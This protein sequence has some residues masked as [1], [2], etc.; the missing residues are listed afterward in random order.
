VVSREDV[1][2]R[3]RSQVPVVGTVRSTAGGDT[4]YA[5]VVNALTGPAAAP[6]IDGTDSRVLLSAGA[7]AAQATVTTYTADGEQVETTKVE[8]PAEATTGYQ[9]GKRAAYLLVTPD[10]GVVSGGVSVT[11]QQ[12]VS[13]IP[14]ESLLIRNREPVVRPVVQ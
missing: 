12:G 1:A 6:L 14:L 8:V 10:R 5:G 7:Q 13:Q 3:L 11:G 4:A 9:P 2:L